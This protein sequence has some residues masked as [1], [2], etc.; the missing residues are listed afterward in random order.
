MTVIDIKTRRRPESYGEAIVCPLCGAN[1]EWKV[2]GLI[3]YMGLVLPKAIA[4]YGDCE[5]NTVIEIEG[6]AVK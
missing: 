1:D 4:C 5:G 6:G 3:T 2:M